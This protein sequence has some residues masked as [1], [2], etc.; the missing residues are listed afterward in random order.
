MGIGSLL[1]KRNSFVIDYRHSD[2][3]NRQRNIAKAGD[4]DDF[5]GD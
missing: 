2:K 5:A 3:Y 4:A 1:G